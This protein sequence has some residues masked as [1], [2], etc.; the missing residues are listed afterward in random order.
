VE[1]PVLEEEPAPAVEA[2]AEAPVE[3]S[4]RGKKKRKRR[5]S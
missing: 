3:E 4:R 1:E 2:V 5:K